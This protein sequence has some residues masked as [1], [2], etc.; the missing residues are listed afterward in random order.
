MPVAADAVEEN[1][2]AIARRAVELAYRAVPAYEARG[3]RQCEDDAGLHVRFLVGS[4]A[5]NEPAIFAD[6]ARWVAELLGRDGIDAKDLAA[7]FSATAE[8]V[9]ELAP[10][11]AQLAAQHLQAGEDALVG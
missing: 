9:R 7:V 2:D 10:D 5:A 1:A 11:A 4:L 3:R 6:Y 8:A